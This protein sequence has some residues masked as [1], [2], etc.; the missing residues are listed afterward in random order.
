M[1]YK[2]VG[3]KYYEIVDSKETEIQF[4]P[5]KYGLMNNLYDVKN[6]VYQ[7]IVNSEGLEKFKQTNEINCNTFTEEQGRFLTIVDKIGST[8]LIYRY[9][10][11]FKIPVMYKVY[12]TRKSI[13]KGVVTEEEMFNLDKRLYDV[14][15][16]DDSILKLPP[17]IQINKRYIPI[18]KDNLKYI[19]ISVNGTLFYR[20]DLDAKQKIIFDVY[21]EAL[22]ILKGLR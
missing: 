15:L 22:K 10:S 5:M 14:Q 13:Y 3:D 20:E 2:V 19:N 1:F 8:P 12:E 21:S 9:V 11:T 16:F 18:R 4:V 17:F 6:T 7:N